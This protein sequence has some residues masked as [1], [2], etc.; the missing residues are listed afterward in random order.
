MSYH[1]K[2]GEFKKRIEELLNHLEHNGYNEG[3]HIKESDVAKFWNI[4]IEAEKE[5]PSQKE[6]ENLGVYLHLLGHVPLKYIRT[7]N[8]LVNV[9]EKWF[10]DVVE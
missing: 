3:Y 10:G 1:L 4:F 2:D 8:T 7:I 5:F 6:I 9:R